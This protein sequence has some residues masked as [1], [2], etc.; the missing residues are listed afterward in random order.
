M[1]EF[2]YRGVMLMDEG[3][4]EHDINRQIGVVVSAMRL[5]DQSVVVKKELS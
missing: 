4:M 5:M 2:K 1:G 3:R